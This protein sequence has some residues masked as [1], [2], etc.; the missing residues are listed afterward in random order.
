MAL[1][2]GLSVLPYKAVKEKPPVIKK[3]TNLVTI[4]PVSPRITLLLEFFAGDQSLHLITD[5]Q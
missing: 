5:L 3:V 4:S 2:A 1:E